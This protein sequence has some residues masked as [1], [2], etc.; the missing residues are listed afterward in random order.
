[1]LPPRPGLPRRLAESPL[2]ANA[3]ARPDQPLRMPGVA[4]LTGALLRLDVMR[5]LPFGRQ[6]ARSTG[7]VRNAS[8][9]RSGRPQLRLQLADHWHEESAV[10]QLVRPAGR[11]QKG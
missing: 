2:G 1:M 6:L 4:K 5:L 9:S 3:A 10:G 8:T 11:D 7:P